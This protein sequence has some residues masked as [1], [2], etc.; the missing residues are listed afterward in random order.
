MFSADRSKGRYAAGVVSGVGS[1]HSRSQ[2]GEIDQKP[3]PAGDR[4]A[5]TSSAATQE[6][7]PG[8][9]QRCPRFGHLAGPRSFLL[10]LFSDHA[11]SLNQKVSATSDA[12][13]LAAEFPWRHQR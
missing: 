1:N 7:S 12:N 6:A 13:P 3:G 2:D 9:T 5:H 10:V 8:A 11:N 4:P